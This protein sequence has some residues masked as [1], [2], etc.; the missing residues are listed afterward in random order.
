MII[1]CHNNTTSTAL[2]NKLG[3]Y[4]S[5]YDNRRPYLSIDFK[6]KTCFCSTKQKG[7]LLYPSDLEV[8]SILPT[9]ESIE[10]Y[11]RQLHKEAAER[12]TAIPRY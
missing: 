12:F 11:I 6:H 8:I 9:I 4:V 7:L 1:C 5:M 2:L 10:G 3:F